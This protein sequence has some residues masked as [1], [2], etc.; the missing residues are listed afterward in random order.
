[1]ATKPTRSP[2]EVVDAIHR[3]AQEDE[4]EAVAKMSDD[5]LAA[6]IRSLEDQSGK[7]GDPEGIANRGAAFIMAALA[8][9]KALAAFR[10]RAERELALALSAIASA[11]KTP[12]LPRKELETRI[13]LAMKRS[14]RLREPIQMAFKNRKRSV[15]SDEELRSFLDAIEKLEALALVLGDNETKPPKN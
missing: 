4:L 8:H 2:A 6:D 14:P 11:P 13:D 7:R 15:A 10:E 9:Q 1:M 12:V 5:E 3:I